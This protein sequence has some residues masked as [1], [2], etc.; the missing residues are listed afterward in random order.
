MK[1]AKALPIKDDR[2]QARILEAVI[3]STLIFISFSVAF[4]LIYSSENP[5]AQETV[6]LNRLGY[7]VLHR[8]AESEVIERTIEENPQDC[9]A[10]L[11]TIIQ[12]FL[13]S[14][15]YFNLTVYNSTGSLSEPYTSPSISVSNAPAE[16]FAGSQEVASVSIIYTSKKGNTY[17]LILKLIRS[18]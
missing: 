11:K 2:G 9:K 10:H 3:A 8:I 13:P 5:F 15:I 7:N 12:E 18:E 16:T 4:Y 17:Y 14:G 6:D 1:L